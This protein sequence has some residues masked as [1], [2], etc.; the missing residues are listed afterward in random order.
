MSPIDLLR[1][2]P[3]ISN[4]FKWVFLASRLLKSLLSEQVLVGFLPKHAQLYHFESQWLICV[5]T[6]SIRMLHLIVK[7]K[8]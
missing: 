5:E 4:Y 7:S 8:P 2:K 6:E 1:L 3:E